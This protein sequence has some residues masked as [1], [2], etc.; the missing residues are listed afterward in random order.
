MGEA[1]TRRKFFLQDVLTT[2]ANG[3]L[4]TFSV[5]LSSTHNINVTEGNLAT[6]PNC[7]D[8]NG[9]L[10]IDGTETT[11]SSSII[12]ENISIIN[13]GVL[14]VNSKGNSNLTID[15]NASFINITAGSVISAN[16]T[17]F[18]GGSGVSGTAGSGPGG[19]GHN[20]DIGGGA[21]HGGEGGE[22]DS[23][24][25]IPNGAQYG[26][27]LNPITVGSGGGA[28]ID[29]NSDGGNGGGAIRLTATIVTSPPAP[30]VNLDS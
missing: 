29:G 6:F 27:S 21:G 26:L 19:G 23:A 28:G 11:I 2:A 24:G 1:G 8:Q 9:D 17:G 16:G 4:P 10:T 25:N 15:I 14:F 12:C 13:N 5:T 20:S 3:N 7:P 22:G 30:S 18:I